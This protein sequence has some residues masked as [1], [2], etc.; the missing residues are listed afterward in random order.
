MIQAKE[1]FEQTPFVSIIIPAFNAERYLS[2][3][4]D[5][6]LC[7]NLSPVEYE[8]ICVDDCSCD[9]TFRILNR[10]RDAYPIIKVVRNEE[11]RGV[12]CSRNIGIEKA[13]G[14]YIWFVDADDFINN[15]VLKA[16]KD[17]C[18]TDDVEL[19]I[20]KG[21]YFDNQLSQ[22]EIKLKAEKRLP[23]SKEYKTAFC[24][25]RLFRSEIIRSHDIRF[26][27]DVRYGEDQLFNFIYEKYVSKREEYDELLYFHRNHTASAMH[28]TDMDSYLASILIGADYLKAFSEH[29]TLS[30]KARTLDYMILRIR[31]AVD[32]IALMTSSESKNYLKLL[33]EKGYYPYDP[34]KEV[35]HLLKNGKMCKKGYYRTQRFRYIVRHKLF[36]RILHPKRTLSNMRSRLVQ[37]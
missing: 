35:R 16:L 21:Y 17:K 32:R 12:S 3:C 27:E 2:E 25:H 8:I 20:F 30:E 10:Y 23:V 11:N 14:K 6:C 28:K 24:T 9:G 22:D 5:S 34:P 29:E 15:N 18:L 26:L 31:F 19:L 4:L 7:Q 1:S 33:H 37:R 36:E 13:S